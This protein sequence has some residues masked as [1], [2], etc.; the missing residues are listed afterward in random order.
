MIC[1]MLSCDVKYV[2]FVAYELKLHH[3]SVIINPCCTNMTSC[4]QF[5]VKAPSGWSPSGIGR[6]CWQ[7]PGPAAPFSCSGETSAPQLASSR[8][9][10]W[11]RASAEPDLTVSLFYSDCR[12]QL[13][14]QSGIHFNAKMVSEIIYFLCTALYLLLSATFSYNFALE[15]IS[16]DVFQLPEE[17]S[18]DHSIM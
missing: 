3:Y 16:F 11:R 9:S 6:R 8:S 17:L 18:S 12:I 2:W 15:N 13:H 1:T 4:L 5:L 10:W 14:L 7:Q